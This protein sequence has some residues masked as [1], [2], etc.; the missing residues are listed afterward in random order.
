MQEIYHYGDEVLKEMGSPIKIDKRNED[1]SEDG[2]SLELME[3]F[4]NPRN[5][6]HDYESG[7]EKLDN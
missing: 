7:V 6:G 4:R 3:F 1:K 2:K 5:W